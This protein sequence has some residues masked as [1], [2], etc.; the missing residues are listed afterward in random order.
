M[1]VGVFTASNQV[2]ADAILD[3]IDPTGD[4]IQF[5]LYR[6]HCILTPEGYYVKDLRIL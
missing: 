4:L 2:Y 3:Y 1:Q 5:R 6:H